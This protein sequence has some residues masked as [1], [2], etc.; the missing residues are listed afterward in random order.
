M[1]CPLRGPP[2]YVS[3]PEPGL[4]STILLYS[5]I[6]SYEVHMSSSR[7]TQRTSIF[8]LTALLLLSLFLAACDTPGNSSGQATLHSSTT[9]KAAASPTATIAP[10]PTLTADS[11]WKIVFQTIK[12]SS[13]LQAGSNRTFTIDKQIPPNKSFVFYGTCR[14]NGSVDFSVKG[15]SAD[16][17]STFTGDISATCTPSNASS[18]VNVSSTGGGSSSSVA[19]NGAG[20][21]MNES[22]V[23]EQATVTVTV[24]GPVKWE[25]VV[26][27]PA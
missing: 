10:P 19:N 16:G 7:K 1:V 12:D 18:S 13:D 24:T 2:G 5:H 14:G 6:L 11:G 15:K 8:F 25:L 26:E 4:N 9:A 27:E 17:A 21:F 22:D 3:A 23:V 20:G